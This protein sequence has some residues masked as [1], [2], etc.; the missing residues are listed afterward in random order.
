MKHGKPQ[1]TARSSGSS[2]IH[3]ASAD[4]LWPWCYIM[5]FSIF[6]SILCA[7]LSP[8]DAVITGLHDRMREEL[9][10]SFPMEEMVKA[11]AWY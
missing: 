7:L 5:Q 2:T 10:C 11:S 4:I 3:E 9:Q 1:F 6:P 8:L